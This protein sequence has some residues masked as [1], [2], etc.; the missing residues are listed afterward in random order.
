MSGRAALSGLAG[1]PAICY[2]VHP[3]V[4]VP[5]ALRL[6]VDG[7]SCL[8]LPFAYRL[9]GHLLASDTPLGELASFRAAG[10]SESTAAADGELSMGPE[11]ARPTFRDL[12][13]IDNRWLAVECSWDGAGYWLRVAEAGLFRGASD[14]TAVR[15]V[16]AAQD[17][18]PSTVVQ[19]AL[20][21]A[22]ILA[23]A[24]RDTWCL[25]AS[26]VSFEGRAVA[27][28]GES[29]DGK[30]TLA[31]YLG[32]EG[33]TGWQREADDIVPVVLDGVDMGALPRFPQLKLPPGAQPG[34]GSPEQLPL[35]AIYRLAPE[36][37]PGHAGSGGTPGAV[38][39]RRLTASQATLALVRHSVATRL[40]DQVLLS[41]HLA[42]CAKATARVPVRDLVYPHDFA[43]LPRVREAIAADLAGV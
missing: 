4:T 38:V 36:R 27:F 22:L 20:G 9:A 41:K 29:G 15:L 25:H 30:S 43:S 26:C 23:L 2:P 19:T 42:F 11:K 21:P 24:L 40:F 12:G 28:V 8:P 35:A 32:Q 37:A 16:E 3:V 7:P 13:W 10:S 33:G 34:A 18:V 5:I 1:G 31:A 17:A 14:G 39:V 6:Q